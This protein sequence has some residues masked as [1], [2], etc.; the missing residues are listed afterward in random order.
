MYTTERS[1]IIGF[2]SINMGEISKL[3]K[4]YA[5][6]SSTVKTY[7]AFNRLST[8]TSARG[9]V[10][11]YAYETARGLLTG[12]SYSDTTPGVAYSYNH[13]GALTQVTDAAGTRSFGYNTYGEAE[14]DSLV[15]GEKTHLVTELR[16]TLGR[17][18]GYTY[19]KDGAVQ[20]T[21]GTSYGTDGRITGAGFLHGGELK[22]FTYTYVT[23]SHLLQGLAMPNNMAL[24]LSYETQRD[25]MTGMVYTRGTTTVVQR[26]YSYDALGRP[27]T[28]AQSRQGGTRNDSFTHND[29]SELTSATLGTDAYGLCVR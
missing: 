27:L 23:G 13:L 24:A 12:I 14:T 15:A 16:D 20:Q 6:G 26:G 9:P 8:E 18:V 1:S 25:L 4:T 28:R 11:A 17:S 19:A 10:A 5:D 29:R 3:R 21:V 7:D 22:E 2:N